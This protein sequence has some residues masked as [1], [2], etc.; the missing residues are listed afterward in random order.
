VEIDKGIR[1]SNMSEHNKWFFKVGLFIFLFINIVVVTWGQ[2]NISFAK[3]TSQYNQNVLDSYIEKQLERAHIPGLSAVIVKEGEIIWT[4]SYG[5]SRLNTQP[6][7]NETLFQLASVS[8]TVTAVA[9]M[10]VWEDGEL[11]LDEDINVYLPFSVLN[12]RAPEKPITVRMLLTHTSSI[13]DN[14]TV[15]DSVYVCD[16]D[17]KISLSR[18]LED[19]FTLNGKYYST[20]NFYNEKPGEVFLYSNVG[21]ALAAYLVEVITGL[22]FNVYC[23]LEIFDPLGME[24]TSWHLTD[25][26]TSQIAMPYKYDKYRHQYNFSTY[27]INIEE[28]FKGDATLQPVS[29]VTMLK[30]DSYQP[31][32]FYAY[33][34]YPDGLLKTSACQLACFLNMFIQHGEYKGIRILQK[35]TVEEMRRIQNPAIDPEQGLIWHYKELA[36]CKLLGHSGEDRGVATEMFFCPEDNVGVILLMNGDRSPGNERFVRKIETRLFEEASAL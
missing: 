23:N 12:P 28:L 11:N 20:L 9:L 35:E 3:I 2:E 27:A 32:G 4:G 18:F 34:D 29:V 21:V 36:G 25:L 13:R 31:Y 10:S 1:N 17:S 15:L 33:P 16:C 8:K 24:E 26:D 6:V 5:W 30:H 7:T 22:P 14:W 19:Y